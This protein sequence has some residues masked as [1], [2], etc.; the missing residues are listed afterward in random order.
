[1]LFLHDNQISSLPLGIFSELNLKNL[2]LNNNEFDSL[3]ENFFATFSSLQ[4]IYLSNNKFETLPEK[5]F[6]NNRLLRIIDLSEN[7]FKSL[8]FHLFE[9]KPELREIILENCNCIDSSLDSREKPMPNEEL[10][11]LKFELTEKCSK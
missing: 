5:I 4:Q 3:P 8:S 7:S 11:R 2:A 10:M 6:D 1:M 9:N